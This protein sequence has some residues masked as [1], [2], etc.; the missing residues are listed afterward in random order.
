M[1]KATFKPKHG[2]SLSAALNK[3]GG[4]VVGRAHVR[5]VN[6]VA[7]SMRAVA[8]RETAKDLG[9]RQKGIRETLKI[10]NATFESPVAELRA[11]SPRFPIIDFRARQTRKGVTWTSGLGRRLI[12]RAFIAR[13]KS[14][15]VGVFKRTQKTK[16][17]IL[18]L[19]AVSVSRVLKKSLP[20]MREVW[21]QRIPVEFKAAMK[22]YSSRS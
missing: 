16:T 18:E 13:M 12:P 1:F 8:V 15:Y 4:P 10:K 17:P 9:A 14:G 22:F 5:A 3:L 20:A 21:A 11:R 2:G 6:R 7:V 19:R